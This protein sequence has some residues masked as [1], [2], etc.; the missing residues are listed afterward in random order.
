[1]TEQQ[2]ENDIRKCL[3]NSINTVNFDNKLQM[4]QIKS[5]LVLFKE[6]G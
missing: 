4:F 6:T 1:M 2:K 5:S 3:S